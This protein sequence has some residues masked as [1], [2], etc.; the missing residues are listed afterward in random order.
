MARYG[1]AVIEFSNGALGEGETLR[2]A[3]LTLDGS[4]SSTFTSRGDQKWVTSVLPTEAFR[5]HQFAARVGTWR[6][7]SGRPT[8]CAPRCGGDPP[9]L[10]L[11][12]PAHAARFSSSRPM[13]PGSWA[14]MKHCVDRPRLPADRGAPGERTR[15]GTRSSTVYHRPYVSIA[16]SSSARSRWP[17][18][19]PLFSAAFSSCAPRAPRAARRIGRSWRGP[20]RCSPPRSARHRCRP[21]S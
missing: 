10:L 14:F 21:N 11:G 4:H 9:S 18:N 19:G 16:T 1:K 13:S 6:F 5:K 2:E 3:E 7:S 20:G 8:S 15:R 12:A 17:T